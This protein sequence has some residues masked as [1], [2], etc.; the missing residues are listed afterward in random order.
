MS[1]SRSALRLRALQLGDLVG[2]PRWDVTAGS[3]EVD[4]HMGVVHMREYRNILNAQPYY[5]TLKCTP[6]FDANGAVPLSALTAGVGDSA[7]KAYRVL[8]VSVAN[9]PYREMAASDVYMAQVAIQGT[10]NVY[11]VWYRDGDN[12]VA[13]D[14]PGLTATGV[15]VNTLPRRADLLASDN[16]LVAWPDDYEDVLAY[17]LAGVLLTKG[18]AEMDASQFC[19][20]QAERL[21]VEMLQDL[22]RTSIRPWQVKFPDTASEW[23]G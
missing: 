7:V 9:I 17:E 13:P 18:A 21:K 5:K 11:A 10:P 19:L 1:I 8:L 15:W 12:L 14:A 22:S 3:G 2:S 4:A 6:T 23:A 16:S 20:A